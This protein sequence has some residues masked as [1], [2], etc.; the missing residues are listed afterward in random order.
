MSDLDVATLK[1]KKHRSLGPVCWK[2]FPRF[3]WRIV[4][5][6]T[7]YWAMAQRG[8]SM[9]FHPLYCAS[10]SLPHLLRKILKAEAT[11]RC[12][13]TQRVSL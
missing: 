11:W 8:D 10:R 7:D 1:W 9:Q 13:K 5:A 2:R 3:N 12:G 6:E 4:K